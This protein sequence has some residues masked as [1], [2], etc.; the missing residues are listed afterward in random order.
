VGKAGQLHTQLS[1]S[2][3]IGNM[4]Q[5]QITVRAADASGNGGQASVTVFIAKGARECFGAA[6]GNEWAFR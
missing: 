5:T 4:I 2:R 1:P 3:A 6:N